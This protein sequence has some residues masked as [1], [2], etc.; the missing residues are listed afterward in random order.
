MPAYQAATDKDAFTD[1][2]R[3]WLSADAQRRF[4]EAT[5]AIAAEGRFGGTDAWTSEIGML[6]E[7]TRLVREAREK[8]DPAAGD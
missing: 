3:E 1:A 4:D 8:E 6:E 7:A 5:N 2:V